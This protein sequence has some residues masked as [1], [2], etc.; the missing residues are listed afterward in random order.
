MIYGIEGDTLK[1]YDPYLYSGKFN[2]STR[3]GKVEVEGNTVYC[4]VENFRE[5]ANY[6]CFFAF[7]ND[8]ANKETPTITPAPEPIVYSY[9]RYVKVNSISV[10]AVPHFVN[11]T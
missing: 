5:Y 2:T 4:S 11:I 7:K 3:R 10:P 8:N 9:T 6:S 1:I